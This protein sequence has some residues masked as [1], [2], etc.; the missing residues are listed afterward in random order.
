MG[1][2]EYPLTHPYPK[3]PLF[4]IITVVLTVLVLPTLILINIVT[5]GYELVP[6]LRP[7]M[8]PDDSLPGMFELPKLL[9]RRV[10][11]CQPKDFGRGDI[12]RLTPSLFQYKVLGAWPNDTAKV[13]SRTMYNG[14]SFSSC[15]IH[16]IRFDFST[17]DYTQT[18]TCGVY[19]PD[20]PHAF[21]ETSAT[22][23]TEMSKDFVGQ[24]YGY[25]F[26]MFNFIDPQSYDYH[27]SVFAVL[28]LMSTDSL[29]T[30]GE[31]PMMSPAALSFSLRVHLENRQYSDVYITYPNGTIKPPNF[32]GQEVEIY[33]PMIYNLAAAVTQAIYLD[34]RSAE[35]NIF[36]NQSLV[37]N[38]FKE[39][40]WLGVGSRS[41]YY[42]GLLPG[43][44]TWAQMLLAGQP[45]NITNTLGKPDNLP[46]DSK[47][48]SNY[49]CPVYRLKP[50]S[51]LLASVFVGT[52]T[53]FLSVWGAW[54]VGSAFIAQRMS[55]QCSECT[56]RKKDCQKHYVREDG[57]MEAGQAPN[58]PSLPTVSHRDSDYSGANKSG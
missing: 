23:A 25:G 31:G 36:L 47:I 57:A 50:K 34:L 28:H 35:P 58:V 39:P 52:A 48:V 14:S 53:M 40:N 27:K 46:D 8:D 43:Y 5:S 32:M 49:M 19:C 24:Y 22:F 9:R 2:I 33:W 15:Q 7:T 55:R 30:I 11:P 20:S 13:E 51:S 12:V 21:L 6:V 37:K 17:I 41:I 42:G 10:P 1:L 54:I 4:E 29:I 16:A 56:F 18:I 38:T 3:K 45:T 44:T 26:N